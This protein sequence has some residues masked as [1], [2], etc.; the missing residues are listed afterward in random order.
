MKFK[1]ISKQFA[2]AGVVMLAAI[3]T[4]YAADAADVCVL[5]KEMKGVLDVLRTLAFVGAAFMIA[6]WAWGYISSGKVGDK[7]MEELKGK[8][9]ALLIGFTLLF[10]IGIVLKFLP[11]IAGCGLEGW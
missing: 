9:V 8:G 11:G 10:S 6:G 3:G 2:V 1:N 5:I 7:P 4:A